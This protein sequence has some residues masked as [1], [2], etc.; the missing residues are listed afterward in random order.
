MGHNNGSRKDGNNR[1]SYDDAFEERRP[2][3]SFSQCCCIVFLA[4]FLC[5]TNT[6]NAEFVYD[7]S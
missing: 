7:D 3:F 2:Y 5:Y 6:L 4:A 1:R